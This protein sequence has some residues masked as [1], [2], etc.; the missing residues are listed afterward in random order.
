MVAVLSA[1]VS[2]TEANPLFPLTPIDQFKTSL[3][4]KSVADK[5]NSKSLGT[6]FSDIVMKILSL[7]M[8][9]ESE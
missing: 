3:L 8:M 5:T 7:S 1:E 2:L 6:P 4:S 9:L